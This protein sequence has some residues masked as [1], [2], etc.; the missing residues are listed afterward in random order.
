MESNAEK[1][2]CP[3]PTRACPDG[4][5]CC[6]LPNHQWVCCPLPYAACCP[7]GYHCCPYG[8]RCDP[9]SSHCYRQDSAT[10]LLAFL[11]VKPG[12]DKMKL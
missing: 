3:D 5:T 8:S 6:L 12:P 11:A 2:I 7:D 4:N 1:V 10:T 9:S